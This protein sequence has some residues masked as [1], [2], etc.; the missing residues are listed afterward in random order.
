MTTEK[1]KVWDWLKAENR[2]ITAWLKAER[3]HKKERLF[4]R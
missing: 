3:K 4:G 2:A 1:Q